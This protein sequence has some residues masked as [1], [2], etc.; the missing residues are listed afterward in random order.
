MIALDHPLAVLED[1]VLVLDAVV[2][3]QPALGFAERHRAAAGMEAHAQLARRLDLAV[4]VV[5]VLEDVA[6][7]EHRGAARLGELGQPDQRAGARAFGVGARPGAV[8]RLQPGEEV[9]VLRARENCAS[10]SG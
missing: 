2:R 1:E 10:A 9:V 5:A 3:R 6:V 8:E 7:V 4:D